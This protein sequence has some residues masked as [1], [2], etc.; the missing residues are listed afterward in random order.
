MKAATCSCHGTLN[1]TTASEIAARIPPPIMSW[2]GRQR[3][4]IIGTP[5][6]Y[7]TPPSEKPAIT[8]PAIEARVS[9]AACSISATNGNR[10]KITMPSTNTA[11]KQIFA[12]GLAN[13]DP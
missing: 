8:T 4:T 6:A 11:P 9:P 13:T 5:S 7:T 10:P 2:S 1:A 3:A 12:R